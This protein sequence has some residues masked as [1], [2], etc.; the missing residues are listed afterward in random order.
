[1]TTTPTP[2]P[3][4]SQILGFNVGSGLS[5]T[6]ARGNKIYGNEVYAFGPLEFYKGLGVNKVV[7]INKTNGSVQNF[8][9]EFSNDT[10]GVLDIWRTTGSSWYMTG[11]FDKYSGSTQQRLVKLNSDLTKDTT[12]NI[13]IGLQNDAYALYYNEVTD[14]LFVGGSFVGYNGDSTKARFIK[15]DGTTGAIDTSIP[16]TYFGN[17]FVEFIT[18]DGNGNLFVGGSFTTVT[19]TTAQNRLVYVS[20]ANGYRVPGF[21]IGTGFNST[22]YSAVYDGVNNRLYVVGAF[23]QYSGVSANGIVCLNATTG[24]IDTGFS[25]GTGFGGGF[26]WSITQLPNGDLVIL[27]N[28]ATYNGVTS[29]RV[30][31]VTS[32][33]T[34]NTTF[35]TN[36]GSSFDFGVTRN[37]PSAYLISNDGTYLYITGNFISFNGQNFNG[38]VRLTI[39]GVLD[40]TT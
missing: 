36:L 6:T 10:L 18:P 3:T 4:P 30:T 34:L 2:T 27:T 37:I 15:V 38:I 25:Y 17:G 16:N 8:Y 11:S 19:G 32:G 14:R 33:G 29:N 39:D 7:S 12:F 9:P 26:G 23:T 22:P 28:S 21:N 20:E 13:G 40:S 5:P 31:R 24:A 35:Q 1:L